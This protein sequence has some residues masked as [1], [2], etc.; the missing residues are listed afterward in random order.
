MAASCSALLSPSSSAI[1]KKR[2]TA[3]RLNPC[4]TSVNKIT[5]NVMNR[6][7]SRCGKASP[8]ENISAR[9]DPD[10]A[11]DH[12]NQTDH[13]RIKNNIAEIVRFQPCDDPGQLQSDQNKN[14][15]VQQ[16]DQGFPKCINLYA[17]IIGKDDMRAEA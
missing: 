6:M 3:G 5:I 15:S 14:H 16:E 4:K 17:G 9:K 12:R 11:D 1:F 7:R 10:N 2:I 13:Y 8:Q